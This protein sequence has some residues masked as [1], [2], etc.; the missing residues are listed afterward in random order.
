MAS[1]QAKT[2]WETLI[3][4]ENK[5][6]CSDQFLPDSLQRIQKKQKKKNKKTSLWLL[7]KP[8]QVGKYRERQKIKIIVPI[9][10]YPTHYREFKKN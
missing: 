6:Y 8:K 2:G 7:F 9:S 4:R 3:K 1:F 5:N 10:S